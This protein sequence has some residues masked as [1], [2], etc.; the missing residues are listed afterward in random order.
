MVKSVIISGSYTIDD[1]T[2]IETFLSGNIDVLSGASVF[3]LPD[4][5]S[6]QFKVGLIQE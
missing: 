5:N 3:I 1:S 2:E 6:G 4:A